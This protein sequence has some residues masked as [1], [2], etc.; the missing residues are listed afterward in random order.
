L[1]C[2][3]SVTPGLVGQ[4]LLRVIVFGGLGLWSCGR[5]H[6]ASPRS[7]VSPR[8]VGKVLIDLD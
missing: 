7:K 3:V 4:L 5:V 8:P 2:A 6:R 1:G